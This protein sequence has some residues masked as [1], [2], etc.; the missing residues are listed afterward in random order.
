MLPFIQCFEKWSWLSTKLETALCLI[1]MLQGH[2]WNAISF[3]LLAERCVRR[4]H[5]CVQTISGFFRS[6][7][8]SLSSFTFGH[9]SDLSNLEILKNYVALLGLESTTK[10]RTTGNSQISKEG[11]ISGPFWTLSTDD[12]LTSDSQQWALA[13]LWEEGPWSP[14]A[15]CPY[16]DANKVWRCWS[17]H[18][19]CISCF[20]N[21]LRGAQTVSI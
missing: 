21:D 20:S 17:H 9:L 4:L 12:A 15:A 11:S 1:K 19:I 2:W 5:H 7:L 8:F 16:D 3:L 18:V 13:Q 14:A 10:I 6:L